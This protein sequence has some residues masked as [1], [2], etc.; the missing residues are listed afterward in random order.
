MLSLKKVIA[1]GG[2]SKEALMLFDEIKKNNSNTEV[3]NT[4]FLITVAN[5]RN[6]KKNFS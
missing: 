3:M 2:I 6:W 1:C 5:G 4:K